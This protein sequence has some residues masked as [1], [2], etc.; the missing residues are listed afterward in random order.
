MKNNELSYYDEIK[1]WDFSKINYEIVVARHT[2]IDAKQIYKTLRKNGILILR[3]VDKLDCWQ[4]KRLFN[5]GL[6]VTYS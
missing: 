1:N 4:L 3:G 5:R 2:C 6:R